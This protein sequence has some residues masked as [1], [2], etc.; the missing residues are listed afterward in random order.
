MSIAI[1]DAATSWTGTILTDATNTRP[2]AGGLVLQ[3]LR[4][5]Q[6]NFA[7]DIRAIGIRLKIQRITPPDTVSSTISLFLELS[8]PPF[9]VSTISTLTPQPVSLPI[10]GGLTAQFLREAY[11]A[12]QFRTYFQDASGNYVGYGV[13]ADYTLPA[14][15]FSTNYP[16]CEMA[17][18]TISQRFMFSRYGLSPPHEPGGV[19]QAARCHPMMRY[20]YTPN[21]SVD[22]SQV[23]YRIASIRFDYR[24][25]LYVDGL[26]NIASTSASPQTANQAG[27]FA[28]EEVANPITG[29]GALVHIG[30]A[31]SRTA[32]A[33]V[34]K[35][36]VYEVTG[37]GLQ[38]GARVIGTRSIYPPTNPTV[39]WDN[40]HWWGFRGTGQPLISAPGAFHAAHLHW[41]WGGA[42]SLPR[43]TIPEIDTSG[44]PTVAQ[45]HPWGNA[46]RTLVDP[47]AWIQ[48]LRVAVAKNDPSLDPT[49]SGVQL[50][51]LSPENWPT[52]FTSLRSTPQDISGGDD[53]VMWYST[54]VH[55]STTFPGRWSFAIF[56]TQ[57]A[58]AVTLYTQNSGTVFLH[59]IFFAHNPE[60]TGFGVGTRDP[61]YF[62]RS[63]S[64][65]RSSPT[66]GRQP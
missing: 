35:P 17:G 61:Q 13:R 36:L 59:G 44:A 64:T 10:M 56:P 52:L 42:G 57:I 21:P 2:P 11:E 58:P 47:D 31:A 24:L 55:R 60:I 62:P 29:L 49:R 38:E 19:L 45:Q 48:T 39:G 63:E 50:L 5:D 65:I 54:E 34:E 1:A 15:W 43:R 37:Q 27:L 23:F 26:L 66:W 8:D 40:L 6:H 30:A 7:R 33:A 9:T 32:F 51:N 3:D 20:E 12:L 18:L 53:I 46:T 22:R 28:D 16:N 14:S 25:H 4:H 41:R